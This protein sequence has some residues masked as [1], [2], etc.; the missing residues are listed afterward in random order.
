MFFLPPLEAVTAEAMAPCSAREYTPRKERIGYRLRAT[1][2]LLMVRG[3]VLACILAICSATSLCE[4]DTIVRLDTVLGNIDVQ[5]FDTI[6][7]GTVENFLNYVERGDYDGTFFHRLEYG[8]VLQGG[9]F[10]WAT[11]PVPTDPNIP[12]EFQVSNT[13]GTIAMAKLQDDP[14]SATSEFFFNLGDNSDNLDNQNGGFT[15]FGEVIGSGMDVVDLLASQQVWDGSGIHPAF[16]SLPLI[17]YSGSGPFVHL[18]EVVNSISVIPAGDVNGDG[19]VDNLDITPFIA[20]LAT[21]EEAFLATYPDGVFQAADVDNDGNV[22]N[23]DITPFIG[24][25]AGGGEAV[26]EPATLALLALGGLV[27]ILSGIRRRRN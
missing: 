24:I 9:G 11:G 12:N 7:P 13:R 18:L 21:P 6:A 3:V 2:K 10:S 22:D 1:E 26:P 20:A 16:G 23:L 8:F 5:L 15:V 14:D 17:N 27:P 4:A 19:N 25:L